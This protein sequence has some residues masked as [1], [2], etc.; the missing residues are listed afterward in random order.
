MMLHQRPN[1]ASTLAGVE[2]SKAFF[3]PCLAG[4]Q[5]DGLWVAHVDDRARCIHLASHELAGEAGGLPVH[6]IVCDAAR[7][8]SAGVVLAHQGSGAV[9]GPL[10]EHVRGTRELAAAGEVLDLTILD[11][12][13]FS[14]DQCTSMRRSGLL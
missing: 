7:F 14:G 4:A 13:V 9:G 11:H 2:A 3:Q 8:G 6:D 10:A 1:P 12:L 5:R